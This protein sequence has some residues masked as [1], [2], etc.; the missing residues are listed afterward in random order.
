LLRMDDSDLR[1]ETA[2]ESES[3]SPRTFA[4]RHY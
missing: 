2:A 1:I 3:T 4:S